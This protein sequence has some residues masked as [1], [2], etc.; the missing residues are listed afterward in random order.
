MLNSGLALLKKHEQHVEQ[1]AGAADG[2][3]R[4]IADVMTNDDAVHGAVELLGNVADE[5]RNAEH[6]DARPWPAFRHVCGFK[7]C[8]YAFHHKKNPVLSHSN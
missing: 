3:Q 5:H 4:V 6:D 7:E 2:C 8:L 1:R